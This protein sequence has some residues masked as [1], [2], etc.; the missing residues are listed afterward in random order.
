[1]RQDSTLERYDDAKPILDAEDLAAKYPKTYRYDVELMPITKWLVTISIKCMI[2]PSP[3]PPPTPYW[4]CNMVLTEHRQTQC[5]KPHSPQFHHN[6]GEQKKPAAKKPQRR[7]HNVSGT[8]VE[9]TEHLPKKNGASSP[10]SH[11]IGHHTRSKTLS[12][13]PNLLHTRNRHQAQG[14]TA[15]SV[16]CPDMSDRFDFR[17]RARSRH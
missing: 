15:E 4:P 17:G 9:M 2:W 14:T 1:M 12:P 5:E 7:R 3:P 10:I 8:H 16:R 11:L 13:S 6:G